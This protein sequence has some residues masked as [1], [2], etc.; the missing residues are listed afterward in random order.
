MPEYS[1][2]FFVAIP[3]S[4]W[5]A[6]DGKTGTTSDCRILGSSFEKI[7]RNRTDAGKTIPAAVFLAIKLAHTANKE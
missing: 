6:E 2:L 1:M 7:G 3:E 4:V 5:I